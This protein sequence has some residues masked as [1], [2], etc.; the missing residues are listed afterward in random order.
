MPITVRVRNSLSLMGADPTVV[1]CRVAI[2]TKD[3]KALVWKT[4]S[5]ECR[6]EGRS[7][8]GIRVSHEIPAMSSAVSM[9]VVKGEEGDL[10]FSATSAD[11]SIRSKH[12]LL[13]APAVFPRLLSIAIKAWAAV[14]FA[15]LKRVLPARGTQPQGLLLGVP[16]LLVRLVCFFRLAGHWRPLHC[17]VEDTP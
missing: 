8:Y 7:C 11:P 4:S 15:L 1:F 17:C 9:N 5:F 3:L 2:P 14:F 6:V 16:P 12:L 13:Y 10:R